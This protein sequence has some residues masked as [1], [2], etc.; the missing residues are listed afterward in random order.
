SDIVARTLEP[1]V[2][3]ELGQS[4]V[5]ENRPG[6]G[7]NIGIGAVAKAQ[8]DGYTILYG[9]SGPLSIGPLLYK[10]LGY[11]LFRD[12]APVSQSVSSPF[13]VFA[14][15]SL[16]PNNAAELIA[17]AKEPPNQI[18]YASSGVGSGLHLVGELFQSVTGTKLVHVPFK[19]ISQALAE[20]FTGRVQL[21]MSTTAGLAP[22]V[23][24]GRMKGIVS[25]GRE[26]SPQLPEV[27]TCIEAALPGFCVSSWH[28]IVAPAGTPRGV[29]NKLQQT[30]K[31]TLANAELRE[32]LLARED[33]TAVASAPDELAKFLRAESTRWAA[34]IKAVGVKGE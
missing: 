4:L 22:H 32:Q 25:T 27:P 34:I 14:T 33:A 1:G 31:T 15:Q 23:R 28:A 20:L 18:N 26:R 11:D 9:N 19:G 12:L 2:S 10:K 3:A 13:V 16:P 24:A 5:I 7:G 6:A 29:V 8:P 21:A 17:Y 30:L